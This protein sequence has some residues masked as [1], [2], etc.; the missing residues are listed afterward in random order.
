LAETQK[1]KPK[2]T[3]AQLRA[4]GR[5]ANETHAKK[6]ELEVS[7][8]KLI[9]HLFLASD[10][11][12]C[13]MQHSETCKNQ[14][15]VRKKDFFYKNHTDLIGGDYMPICS[16]C[17]KEYCMLENGDINKLRLLQVLA[18][19]NKPY[20]EETYESAMNSNSNISNR[21]S[22]YF[23]QLNMPHTKHLCFADS[24]G[25]LLDMES[26][27]RKQN[28]PLDIVITDELKIKWG[29]F[30]QE[31][32]IRFLQYSYEKYISYYSV[33][34][35]DPV[36]V[37]LIEDLCFKDLQLRK[38]REGGNSEKDIIKDKQELLKTANLSP[39]Q[40]SKNNQGFNIG[41]WIKEREQTRPI[42]EPLDEFKDPDGILKIIMKFFGHIVK[43]MGLNKNGLEDEVK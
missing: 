39:S 12:Y 15:G 31:P 36:Q 1:A 14:H 9:D 8:R 38:A 19:V 4:Q 3:K 23:R 22:E 13:I 25:T 28:D 18:L 27:I 35:A 7:D 17:L 21:V 37:G 24:D 11:N 42:S 34:E 32:D 33:N 2:R 10:Y 41:T 40:T 30:L 26:E 6:L 29:A 5:K 43:M 16:D 20:K